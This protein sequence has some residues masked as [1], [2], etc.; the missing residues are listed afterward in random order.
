MAAVRG[1]TPRPGTV[2]PPAGICAWVW[3]S[4]PDTSLPQPEVISSDIALIYRVVLHLLCRRPGM[5]ESFGLLWPS[6]TSFP[7]P[8]M[9]AQLGTLLS[10]PVCF[11]GPV[12]YRSSG[13]GTHTQ[14]EQNGQFIQS[15]SQQ[16]S[17]SHVRMN[18]SIIKTKNLP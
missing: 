18:V 3:E 14:I 4:S 6:A 2:P 11:G 9:G 13:R 1:P 10:V 16:A 5:R 12:P 17:L 7:K 8:G 15:L